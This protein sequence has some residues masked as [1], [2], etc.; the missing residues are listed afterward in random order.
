MTNLSIALYSQFGLFLFGVRRSRH[1]NDDH[2]LLF[3]E[4]KVDFDGEK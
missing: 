1:P 2:V 4:R 3:T